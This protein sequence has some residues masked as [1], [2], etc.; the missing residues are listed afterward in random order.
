MSWRAASQFEVAISTAINWMNR[1]RQTG[2]VAL[3]QMV[4]HKPRAISGSHRDWLI[5]RCR[6]WDFT[7][8]G[9]VAELAE[10]GLK[11]PYRS[12]W[13]FVHAEKLSYKKPCSPA[14]R[15]A[16]MSHAA[17]C[18]GAAIRTGLTR[19]VWSLSTRPGPRPTWH[20]CAAG[21]HA[22]TGC[23]AKC[24]MAT[25]A[26]FR[27]LGVGGSGSS[28]AS[29]WT[30]K[31][32]G[33]NGVQRHPVIREATACWGRSVLLA[34]TMSI[35]AGLASGQPAAAQY[36]RA[37]TN[38]PENTS[39]IGLSYTNT[40]SDWYTDDDIP[41]GLKANTNTALLYYNYCFA[42]FTGNI[43][44]VGFNLPYNLIYGYNNTTQRVTHNE[45]GF[46]DPSLTVDYNLFGAKA[47]SKEEFARTPAETFGGLHLAFTVPLGS[48]DPSQVNNIGSNRYA[49]RSPSTWPFRGMTA[50]S[51]SK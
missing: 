38:L 3:G 4:G 17:A 30:T 22:G 9:L 11:L 48:Y 45:A 37:Y 43:A 46:G 28:P 41:T 6:A 16:R 12:V 18:N 14:N 26:K 34:L 8:R 40:R 21:D 5:E 49:A 27:L 20:R 24:L 36:A 1:F 51:G 25:G 39:V 44:C 10:H 33:R 29:A 19:R 13:D 2:S 15:I 7:L 47:M 42:G 23:S 50:P 32:R 35:P 31:S